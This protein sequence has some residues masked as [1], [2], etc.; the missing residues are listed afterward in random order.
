MEERMSLSGQQ[1]YI[2][3]VAII[4]ATLKYSSG[5]LPVS[6]MSNPGQICGEARRIGYTGKL[7]SDLALYRLKIKTGK[8]HP[9]FTLPGLY[10]IE[11]G[12]FQ[13]YEQWKQ[14]TER[15]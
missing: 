5:K 15:G 13:D 11:N 2:P 7:D 9:T 8:D 12:V 14:R 10:I 4:R 1:T 3:T 6:T